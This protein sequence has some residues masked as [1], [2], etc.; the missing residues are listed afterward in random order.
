MDAV[1]PRSSS[2]V[3]R[4]IVAGREA[5]QKG[6]VKRVGTGSTISIW[7]DK[8]IPGL[9]TLQP[10]VIPGGTTLSWVSELINEENWTWKRDLIRDVFIPPEAEAILNIPL[11]HGGVEDFLAWAHEINGNYSV[12]S[13]YRALVTRKKRAAL[14]EGAATSTSQTE[15]QMWK[16]LWK[17]KVLP[18]VRVFWW[19]VVR[20]ILR[21][22]CTL[23][24]RYIQPLGR[25]K[26]CFAMDEDLMHALVHCT[27]AK[28]FWEE[29]YDWLGVRWPRLH[30]ETWARDILEDPQFTDTQRAQMISVMWAIWH[31][32]NRITHDGEKLDPVRT[33]RRI[34]EDLSV[35]EIPS[36]AAAILPGYG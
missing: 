35:L 4:A 27:H 25:C 36:S 11:R 12:K 8:W 22:E 32:R 10:T 17:L 23:R 31:S 16:R 21:D 33:V 28:M 26:V 13:A 20:K 6:L 24:H 34:K 9:S 3:W 2:A 29:A 7:E 30:P 14:E 15:G 19:P 1:V 5:L 18:K